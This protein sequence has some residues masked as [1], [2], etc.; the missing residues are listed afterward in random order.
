MSVSIFGME[1][2][3]VVCFNCFQNRSSSIFFLF[4]ALVLFIVISRVFVNVP[5]E[6]ILEAQHC[7][8]AQVCR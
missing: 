5:L 1:I 3:E 2:V 6:K 7:L 8:V 4:C